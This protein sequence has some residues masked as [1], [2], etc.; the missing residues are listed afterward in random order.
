M[1]DHLYGHTTVVIVQ[2]VNRV[3]SLSVCIRGKAED[4]VAMMKQSRGTM[5]QSELIGAE[6][7]LGNWHLRKQVFPLTFRE[8][9]F[10]FEHVFPR[11]RLSQHVSPL[12]SLSASLL[13]TRPSLPPFFICLALC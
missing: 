2:S 1:G 11:A 9:V 5:Q 7:S 8:H 13:P 12:T 4:T 3:C 10:P 6:F